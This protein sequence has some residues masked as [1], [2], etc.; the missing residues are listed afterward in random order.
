MGASKMFKIFEAVVQYADLATRRERHLTTESARKGLNST[1]GA[2]FAALPL[3]KPVLDLRAPS[4]TDVPVLLLNQPNF[5]L[6]R[7]AV[8]VLKINTC[9]FFSLR[10]F[11]LIFHRVV[12][13]CSECLVP[14]LLQ[15]EQVLKA[16]LVA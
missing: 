2:Q 12:V 3:V 8:C 7:V 16:G 10:E 11:F 13:V 5:S 9:E 15:I 1:S 4:S 6:T 14:S